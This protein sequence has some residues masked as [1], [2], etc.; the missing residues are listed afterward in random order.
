MKRA[1]TIADVQE[2][3]A[4]FYGIDPALL[5]APTRLGEIVK[6]RHIAMVICMEMLP[7][8]GR[9][10]SL[11]FDRHRTTGIYVRREVGFRLEWDAAFRREFAA[12]RERVRQAAGE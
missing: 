9:A 7:L 8:S 2:E 1:L 5:R 10:I 3:V 12:A 11:G 6:A 4:A